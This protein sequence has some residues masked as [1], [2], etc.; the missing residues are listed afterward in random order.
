[1][2]SSG[3]YESIEHEGI[4]NRSDGSSVTVLITTS[5]ACSGC[6]AEEMCTM[7]GKEEKIIDVSGNY[8]LSPG[9]VVTVQMKK[10]M[11]Y[12]ALLLGYI[13]PFFL[14]ILTL[15]LLISLSVPELW[16]GLGTILMLLP[17]YLTLWF[18]RKRINS[19]FSFTIKT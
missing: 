5:S 2:T 8:N 19:K 11:G 16:A 1:M 7:S 18:F 14:V 6:H 9:D 4:V 10:S 15:I 12:T 13:L 17:Y 3:K